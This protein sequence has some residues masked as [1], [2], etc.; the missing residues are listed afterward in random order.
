M[1]CAKTNINNVNSGQP[2]PRILRFEQVFVAYWEETSARASHTAVAAV[3]FGS[4]I[5]RPK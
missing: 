3:E 4:A 5:A 2:L 1:N